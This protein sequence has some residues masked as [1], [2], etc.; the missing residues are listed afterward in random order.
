[1]QGN[2]LFIYTN[3]N[4]PN[5]R[6]VSADF[7]NPNPKNWKDIIPETQNVLNIGTGGGKLFANYLKDATSLIQQ[8]DYSGKLERDIELPAVGTASGF[9]AK[10]NDK[11]LYYSFTSYVYP[12]SIF[13]YNITTGESIEYKKAGVDFDSSL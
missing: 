2:K 8:Y 9:S 4:A 3:L 6:V 11:E 5:Y 13:K 10:E 12:P 1:N 7:D